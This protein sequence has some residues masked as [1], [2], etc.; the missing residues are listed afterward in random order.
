MARRRERLTHAP[1]VEAVID[2]RL[3]PGA[4]VSTTDLAAARS[5]LGGDY[6]S[7]V[8]MRSVEATFSA[9][10]QEITQ[11]KSEVGVLFRSEDQKRVVQFRA[12]GFAFN[13][14]EPY[15]D[16][17]TVFGE[18]CRLWQ[19]YYSLRPGVRVARLAVRYINRMTPREGESLSDYLTNPPA[20]PPEVPQQLREYLSRVVVQDADRGLSAVL[21]QALEPGPDRG[22]AAVLLDVDAFSELQLPLEPADPEIVNIFSRLRDLKN[23]IFYACITE[24]AAERYE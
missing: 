15:T 14:L 16:W 8:P 17:P 19:I 10:D 23:Q 21:V 5:Q 18:A 12:N 22:T 2:I 1:I 13:R 20:L 7:A 3:A 9:D 11:R 24:A 6:T 4:P